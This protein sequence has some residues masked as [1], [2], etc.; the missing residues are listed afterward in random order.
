METFSLIWTQEKTFP[1]FAILCEKRISARIFYVPLHRTKA[2]SG[3]Q[4]AESITLRNRWR[5]FERLKNATEYQR[6]IRYWR[7]PGG[8]LK[9]KPKG[10]KK[11]TSPTKYWFCRTCLFLVAFWLFFQWSAWGSPISFKSLIF[12]CCFQ[13]FKSSPPISQRDTFRILRA[14]LWLSFVTKV[15]LFFG[16]TAITALKICVSYQLFRLAVWRFWKRA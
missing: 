7:A 2:K 14:T 12:S 10:D 5:W 13:S 6:F 8:S 16:K 1:V 15:I 3:A 9:E 4:N 11:K